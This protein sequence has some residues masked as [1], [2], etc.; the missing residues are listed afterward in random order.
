MSGGGFFR[1]AAKQHAADLDRDDDATG[2]ERDISAADARRSQRGAAADFRLY[3]EERRAQPATA[4]AIAPAGQASAT[5]TA[6]AQ[7]GQAQPAQAIEDPIILSAAANAQRLP[8][9][10]RALSDLAG[11]MQAA[12]DRL[13]GDS[14]G[15]LGLQFA[16]AYASTA[17]DVQRLGE[18][19]D[20]ASLLGAVGVGYAHDPDGAKVVA[21]DAER[22]RLDEIRADLSGDLHA[23]TTLIVNAIRP[24]QFRRREVPGVAW[25]QQPADVPTFIREQT[26]RS[27]LLVDTLDEIHRMLAAAKGQPPDAG[28]AI[29]KDA[30]NRLQFWLADHDGFLFLS[31][32]LGAL[33]HGDVLE[34]RGMDGRELKK[35]V[36]AVTRGVPQT[37]GDV[38]ATIDQARDL[39]LAGDNLGAASLLDGVRERVD[40][41]ADYGA[42]KKALPDGVHGLTLESALTIAQEGREGV[43]WMARMLHRGQAVGA[44]SWRHLH[45]QVSVSAPVLKVTA[46]EAPYEESFLTGIAPASKT[47]II[48]S[49]VLFGAVVTGGAGATWISANAAIVAEAAAGAYAAAVALVVRNPYAATAIAEFAASIGFNVIDAGGVSNFLENLKTPEGVLQLTMDI[50]VLMQSGGGGRAGAD[51]DAPDAPR[52]APRAA[53]PDE[54]AFAGQVRDVLDRVRALKGAT[55]EWARQRTPATADVA[56]TP[57]GATVR[58]PGNGPDA[59]PDFSTIYAQ[60]LGDRRAARAARGARAMWPT[61]EQWDA[62]FQVPPAGKSDVEIRKKLLEAA[63]EKH[64]TTDDMPHEQQADTHW[65]QREFFDRVEARARTRREELEAE[66]AN[67]STED[68]AWHDEQIADARRVEQAA[69]V[70]PIQGSLPINHEF[71]G[72]AISV[73]SIDAQLSNAKL[74]AETRAKLQRL[75]KVM[76]EHGIQEIRYTEAGYPD[77]S[78]FAYEKNGVKADVEI[79]LRG[80]RGKDDLAADARF[81]EMVGDPDFEAPDGF[82]WHHSEQVG[83]MLLVPTGIHDAFKHTGAIPWY[84]ILT[85]DYDAYRSPGNSKGTSDDS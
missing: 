34:Q 56:A 16:A 8:K 51:A 82:T 57:D 75:R 67:L 50:L 73:D 30:A 11:S 38:L 49:G 7:S 26:I 3:L 74:P 70:K 48:T 23:R 37:V 24:A 69:K 80:R 78:P 68:R 47:S 61:A 19:L 62:D 29:R 25:Q 60:Q 66:A 59:A 55:V 31:Q 46:G 44:G 85:G 53:V 42:I 15:A 36:E 4:L 52:R 1:D 41:L 83:R 10:L 17:A 33:G 20:N 84:R 2:D 39:D 35:T 54:G 79:Y 40:Q 9:Q 77:F 43:A 5:A 64:P 32:A 65:K 12:R 13:D 18:D 14:V 76:V 27:I 81:G 71:A 22:E 28:A 58:V 6:S 72:K 21:R 45:Q 63:Q